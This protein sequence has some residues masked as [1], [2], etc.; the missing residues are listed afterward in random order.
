M[1]LSTRKVFILPDEQRAR[2]EKL[3]EKRE[4]L[5][6]Q[7][8]ALINEASKVWCEMSNELAQALAKESG[9]KP[10]DAVYNPDLDVKAIV[11]DNGKWFVLPKLNGIW[12]EDDDSITQHYII[13]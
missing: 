9:Y 3:N 11:T 7:S 13:E 5:L 10:G 4:E 2:V 6:K 12:Q 8:T 1:S